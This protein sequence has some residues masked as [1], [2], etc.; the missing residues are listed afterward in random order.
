VAAF[1]CVLPKKF[2]PADKS[3]MIKCHTSQISHFLYKA[4]VL[5][6]YLISINAAIF[7]QKN[8]L[9]KVTYRKNIS[10]RLLLISGLKIIT[11]KHFLLR[12][13]LIMVIAFCFSFQSNGQDIYGTRKPEGI[14]PWKQLGEKMIDLSTTEDYILVKSTS[15]FYKLKLKAVDQSVD[16]ISMKIEFTNGTDN[17]VKLDFT[18]EK[19]RESREIEIMGSARKIQRVFIKYKTITPGFLGT[20]KIILSGQKLNTTNLY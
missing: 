19:G 12:S 5:S 7:I 15:V 13:V 17:N 14:G 16:M 11:M 3:R 8:G 4:T 1:H 6:L 10:S 20:T 2:L 9:V 18:L